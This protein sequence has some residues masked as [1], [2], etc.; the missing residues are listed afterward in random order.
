MSSRIQNPSILSSAPYWFE[1]NASIGFLFQRVTDLLFYSSELPKKVV[2][3]VR[4]RCKSTPTGRREHGWRFTSG[5]RAGSWAL[6]CPRCWIEGPPEMLQTR[7]I[8]MKSENDIIFAES[9]TQTFH[10]PLCFDRQGNKSRRLSPGTPRTYYFH[11]N[12][13]KRKRCEGLKISRTKYYAQINHGTVA[14]GFS[15][16]DQRRLGRPPFCFLRFE[17]FKFN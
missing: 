9:R 6:A 13:R 7:S 8:S 3:R 17:Y 2:L 5:L 1:G 10:R 11:L 14:S 15:M 16:L 4:K 12:Y